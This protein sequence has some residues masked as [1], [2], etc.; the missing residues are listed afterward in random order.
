[1]EY[2][3]TDTVAKKLVTGVL[4]FSS[5]ILGGCASSPSTATSLTT[6]G[7][8]TT[9][10]NS[11][12]TLNVSAATSLSDALK[13]INNLYF[14]ANP[15][16]T[17]VPNFA[18]SG[19]LQTQIQNGA[20]VD[21]FI[22]A[23]A[24]QIDNL[25]K[26]QLIIDETRIDLLNNRVVLVVPSGNIL[27]IMSFNDLIKEKVKKVAVPDPKSSP[28]G[29]Y[30]QMAFNELGISTQILTKEILGSD[31]R[32]VL[33]YVEGGNVDAAIVFATD[34]L[35][36]NKVKV[37]ASAPD[38]VNSKVVYPAVVIKASRNPDA[39]KAYLAFLSGPQSKLVF[40]KYG[41][42]VVGK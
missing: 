41:F 35:T 2:K 19:T 4:L 5:L 14:Q 36:S 32:Q 11:P 10:A 37:V 15:N 27:G 9:S 18:S 28:A 26:G 3:F 23:A 42:S 29:T 21:I 7:A 6:T 34:A 24:L 39:A 38:D 20:P 12:V 17:L 25:Q 40:E 22:S 8:N 1:V 13:E 31:V 30:A 16:V 33:T